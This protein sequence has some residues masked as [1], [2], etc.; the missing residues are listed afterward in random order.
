MNNIYIYIHTQTQRN[1]SLSL[2]FYISSSSSC[3]TASTDIPDPLSPSLPI[4]HRLRQV[5][6][7]TSRI[8][9]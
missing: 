5:F 3:R 9:T 1:I 7:V 8:I 6:K 4:I 2:S